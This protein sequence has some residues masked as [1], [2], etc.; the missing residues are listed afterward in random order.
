MIGFTV[1]GY[2][3]LQSAL[4]AIMQEYQLY[5][6][7]FVTMLEF[8]HVMLT[9][10]QTGRHNKT[11]FLA[12]LNLPSNRADVFLCFYG[13]VLMSCSVEKNMG[14][15]GFQPTFAMIKTVLS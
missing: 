2:T 1:H 3:T 10:L 9:D 11:I 4:H 14:S 13:C 8:G 6:H 7:F 12:V 15:F 5:D